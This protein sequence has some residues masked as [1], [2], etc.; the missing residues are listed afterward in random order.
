GAA[1]AWTLAS[2]LLFA[3][4]FVIIDVLTPGHLRTQIRDNINAAILVSAKML[5]VAAIVFVSVWTAPD[6]LG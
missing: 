6:E 1:A 4:G 3:V 5:A 2:F